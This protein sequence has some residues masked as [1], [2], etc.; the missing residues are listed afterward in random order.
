[1]VSIRSY[2]PGLAMDVLS[3]GRCA[4]VHFQPVAVH[5]FFFFLSFFGSSRVSVC[6]CERTELV[7]VACVYVSTYL[8]CGN[9]VEGADKR[10]FFV[11]A[12]T[13]RARSDLAAPVHPER[14]GA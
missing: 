13:S 2:L 5:F 8:L 6:E 7:N 14:K 12:A 10:F 1:M 4:R 3:N 11:A 9:G